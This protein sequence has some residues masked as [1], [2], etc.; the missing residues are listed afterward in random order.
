MKNIFF[1]YNPYAG[2]GKIKEKLPDILKVFDEAGFDVTLYETKG[3]KDATNQVIEN[4]FDYD[5]VVCSGGDGT[6]SEVV[7]G[8]MQLPKEK[9]VPIGFIPVGSTNDTSKSYHLSMDVI[10]SAKIA[11]YGKK[12]ATDIGIFNREQYITYVSSFGNLSAVSCFTP[13]ELKKK[14]GYAAYLKEGIK[15]LLHLDSYEMKI[16]YEDYDETKELSGNFY[17]GMATN[18]L[19]VGG[20][21]DITG[22]KV[23]LDDGLYEVAVLNR[24]KNLGGFAK[25]VDTMLIKK[26][27]NLSNEIVHKFKTRR[28][29]FTSKEEL[30]WVID[31]ENAGKYKE[32]EI[33][34]EKGAVEIFIQ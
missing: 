29:K 24:P 18:T 16:E 1:I 15:V 31:G 33:E 20:F 17:L 23:L 32:V 25:Q 26:D 9:R 22:A 28:I 7:A 2:K 4:A 13:Q 19:S 27:K 5:R 14:F 12:F 3:P 8:M 34:V 30:Q 6:L 21:K 11:A 10:E